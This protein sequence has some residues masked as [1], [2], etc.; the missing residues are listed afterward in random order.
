MWHHESF[1]YFQI[2][3][4]LGGTQQGS[5]QSLGSE[6]MSYYLRHLVLFSLLCVC[7]SASLF[8]LPAGGA[9]GGGYAQVIPMEEVSDNRH[10]V[11]RYHKALSLSMPQLM[12]AF[13]ELTQTLRLNKKKSLLVSDFWTMHFLLFCFVLSYLIFFYYQLIS[14]IPFNMDGKFKLKNNIIISS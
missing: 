6:L 1:E 8:C 4:L 14:A 10:P 5:S 11:S 13:E 7:Q 2:S 12:K 9:A 3:H